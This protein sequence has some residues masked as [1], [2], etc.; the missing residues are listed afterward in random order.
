M[1]HNFIYHGQVGLCE[2]CNHQCRV[3]RLISNEG[4]FP[5]G[6]IWLCV[7]CIIE[8]GGVPSGYVVELWC[9]ECEGTIPNLVLAL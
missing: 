8:D 4:G 7:D 1:A 6:H 3:T 5:A 9:T 2:G